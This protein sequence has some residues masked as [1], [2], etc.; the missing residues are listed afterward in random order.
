MY[1]R[2]TAKIILKASFIKLRLRNCVN[3]QQ[4]Q[5]KLKLINLVNI[6]FESRIKITTISQY[7]TFLLPKLQTLYTKINNKLFLLSI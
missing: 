5:S 1:L 6:W 2:K 3:K 4:K 7:K